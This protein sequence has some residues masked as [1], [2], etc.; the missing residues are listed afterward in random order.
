[1]TPYVAIVY[2]Q[3]VERPV[4]NGEKMKP[5]QWLIDIE[6]DPEDDI[7]YHLETIDHETQRITVRVIDPMI[8]AVHLY[9][10]KKK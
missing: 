7:R 2:P 4:A 10:V 9:P 1:M 5:G 8:V 6:D 3:E